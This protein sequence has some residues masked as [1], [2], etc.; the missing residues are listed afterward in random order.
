[1]E[2]IWRLHPTGWGAGKAQLRAR[3]SGTWCGEW[4]PLGKWRP[5]LF[6]GGSWS[7]EGWDLQEA[8]ASRS[9]QVYCLTNG[10]LQIPGGKKQKVWCL[11]GL[12]QLSIPCFPRYLVLSLNS[13]FTLCFELMHLW[14]L[15]LAVAFCPSS[16]TLDINET[17][18][19]MQ[20]LRISPTVAY[21]QSTGLYTFLK[22]HLF[23][24]YRPLYIF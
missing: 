4:G 17:K 21:H 7:L 6:S 16:W 24:V 11:M 5:L 2:R 19:G 12:S 3:E 15:A 13:K 23:K 8:A 14:Q 1:M 10:F 22:Q 18:N 20:G 9:S